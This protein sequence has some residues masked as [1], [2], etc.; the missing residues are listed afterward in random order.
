MHTDYDPLVICHI[1]VLPNEDILWCL[2]LMLKI[3]F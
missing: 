2:L 1:P 3:I